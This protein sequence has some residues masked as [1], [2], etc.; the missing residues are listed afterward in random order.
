[1]ELK[2]D[3]V[4]LSP[5]EQELGGVAAALRRDE[6]VIIARELCQRSQVWDDLGKVLQIEADN[7]WNQQSKVNGLHQRAEDMH[8][9]GKEILDACGATL[10]DVPDWEYFDDK[11]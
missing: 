9:L 5:D 11:L 8:R 1:M 6:A 7:G 4:Y 3:T 10:V 2:D